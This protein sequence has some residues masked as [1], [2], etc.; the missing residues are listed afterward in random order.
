MP[1]ITYDTFGH[2]TSVGTYTFKLPTSNIEAQATSSAGKHGFVQGDQ[3]AYFSLEG[4]TSNIANRG[5]IFKE[6]ANSRA[7]ASI[8]G[9]GNAAFNGKVAI[10]TSGTTVSN[11]VTL[12]YDSANKCLNFVFN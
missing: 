6:T 1:K 7:I 10:G 8:S 5:W 2:I 9:S 11:C 4:T 3:A 12:E